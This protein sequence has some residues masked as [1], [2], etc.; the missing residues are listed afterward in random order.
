[1][2]GTQGTQFIMRFHTK[3]VQSLYPEEFRPLTSFRTDGNDW[4]HYFVWYR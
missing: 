1:M 3:F 4:S 2:H